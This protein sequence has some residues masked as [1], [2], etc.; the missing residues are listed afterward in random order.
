MDPAPRARL[1]QLDPPLPLPR[2]G[3]RQPEVVVPPLAVLLG[4]GHVDAGRG[5]RLRALAL[6]LPRQRAEPA[7][8][9]AQR[10]DRVGQVHQQLAVLPAHDVGAG[11]REERRGGDGVRDGLAG[12]VDARRVAAQVQHP[13]DGRRVELDDARVEL[14]G[15]AHH[16]HAVG[17][18]EMAQ[19]PALVLHPVLHADDRRGRRRH[20]ELRERMLGVL[21][22][23]GEQ[24]DG[25]LLPCHAV[26]VGHGADGEGDR[27]VGCL[28][29]E[30]RL[31]R[32]TVLAPGHQRDVEALLVEA[33]ADGAPDCTRPQ[34]HEPHGCTLPRAKL[35][36][37]L[38]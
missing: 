18:R 29:H 22:L 2:G 33:G 4:A 31:E 9:P 34:D 16:A 27:L 5:E 21:P 7:L 6:G 28:E 14:G 17:A 38:R 24:H 37:W 1:C 10:L 25:V 32:A 12:V 30:A 8:R 13:R 20:G 19:H 35:W 36:A 3:R 23:H 11:H 26:E 15:G